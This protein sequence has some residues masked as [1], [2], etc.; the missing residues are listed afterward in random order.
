MP[1]PAQPSRSPSV[2]LLYVGG[3]TRSGS[4]LLAHL[5]AQLEGFWAIGEL[6]EIWRK[7]V[8]DDSLCGCGAPFS[9]CRFW[10]SVATEAFGGWS[11]V[12]A[13]EF[14]ETSRLIGTDTRMVPALVGRRPEPAR[15]ERYRSHMRRL[16]QVIQQITGADVL[17]DSSKLA[18]YALVFAGL[19]GID[20]RVMHLTR[21]SRAVAFSWGRRVRKPDVRDAG[22]GSY[23]DVH[24]THATALRWI[25]HNL[26]FDVL[27][28]FRAPVTRIRYERLAASPADETL[29]ALGRLS[30]AVPDGSRSRLQ[31]ARFGSAGIHMIGGNPMRFARSQAV[32]PDEEWRTAMGIPARTAVLLMTWPLLARYARPSMRRRPAR[33][34]R[35]RAAPEAG[36]SARGTGPAA[37]LGRRDPTSDRTS[38]S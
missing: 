24:P 12:D 30:L 5:L 7:G 14:A 35:T 26:L 6:R 32:R 29:S 1:S 31:D 38:G 25:Y 28:P 2:R 19:P 27:V 36:G 23:M 34:T 8:I 21:D 15:L 33:R 20:M 17:V 22:A 11:Q 37:R 3:F 10:D 4:T 18:P 13:E 16:Y 9:A